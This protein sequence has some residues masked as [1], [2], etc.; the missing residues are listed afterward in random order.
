MKDSKT[1][2]ITKV[3]HKCGIS[4]GRH[5]CGVATWH[6]DICDICGKKANVTEPRDFGGVSIG[7][8]KQGG[9]NIPLEEIERMVEE[10]KHAKIKKSEYVE[11]KKLAEALM[12][13]VDDYEEKL[14]YADLRRQFKN[15]L[16]KKNN[17][18]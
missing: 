6:E 12:D 11:A 18:R 2:N 3:C 16:K 7:K 4:Y 1:E 5:N 13:M 17:D 15:K 10:L 8:E 14:M 9:S